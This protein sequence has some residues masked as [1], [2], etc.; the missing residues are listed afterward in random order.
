MICSEN[1]VGGRTLKTLGKLLEAPARRE[2]PYSESQA[3][4]CYGSGI[5]VDGH[6]RLPQGG[7]R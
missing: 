1:E 7:V 2:V 5:F 6:R 4:G 3:Q